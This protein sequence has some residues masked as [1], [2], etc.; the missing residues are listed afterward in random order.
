V[1]NRIEALGYEPIDD[2]PGQFAAALREDIAAIRATAIGG[3]TA[4]R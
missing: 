1:K 3:S 4:S 2:A